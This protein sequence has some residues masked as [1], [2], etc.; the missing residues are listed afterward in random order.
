MLVFPYKCI[1]K[2]ENK[3]IKTLDIKKRDKGH[4]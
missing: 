1:K 4:N 3:H 2:K